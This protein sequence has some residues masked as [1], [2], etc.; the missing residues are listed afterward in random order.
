G[1]APALLR[2]DDSRARLAVLHACARAPAAR[3]LPRTESVAVPRG[4]PGAR[5]GRGAA[6]E[7]VSRAATAELARAADPAAW[8]GGLQPAEGERRGEA[9]R[10]SPEEERLRERGG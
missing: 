4:D 5:E 2:R 1:G 8:S 7:L 3:P 6:R 10:R 9:G